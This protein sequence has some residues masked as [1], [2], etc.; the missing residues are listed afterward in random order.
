MTI[1]RLRATLLATILA[2]ACAPAIAAA[3]TPK[4]AATPHKITLPAPKLPNQKAH[5]EYTVEVN[6]FGQ[7]VRIKSGHGSK[8]TI[9]NHQTYGNAL[10][11]WI[12]HPDGSA[13]AG[14]YKVDYDYDPKTHDVARH[15]ALISRGG[16]WA[17]QPGAANV[18]LETA[19]K[20]AEAS[21]AAAKAKQ[22]QAS[23]LPSLNDITG[24]KTPVPSSAPL[25]P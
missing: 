21:A 22:S 7:V 11:M 16:S 20:E 15:I 19:K 4:P 25:P 6:K 12:R 2:A 3:A 5:I 13:V 9:L 18:M 23:H 17:N 1:A 14:L 24:K 8:F 10:Q